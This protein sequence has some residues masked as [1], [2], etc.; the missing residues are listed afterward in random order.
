MEELILNFF[1]EKDCSTILIF[2][3]YAKG[4]NDSSSDLDIAVFCS[5]K[6]SDDNLVEWA[7][8]LSE[9]LGLEIDLID[10]RVANFMLLE[11]ILGNYRALKL[12]DKDFI[13]RLTSKMLRDRED[14]GNTIEL[15]LDRKRKRFLK[16]E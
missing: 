6:V 7:T 4:T 3:S 11:E 12:A 8:Q 14:I 13:P 16:D 10:L 5:Q 15:E 1:S 9:S 2:G